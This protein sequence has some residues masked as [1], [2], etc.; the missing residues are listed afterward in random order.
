MPGADAMRFGAAHGAAIFQQSL[1][2]IPRTLPLWLLPAAALALGIDHFAPAR[3]RRM[4]SML[5]IGTAGAAGL[6]LTWTI[7]FAGVSGA[8]TAIRLRTQTN[9]TMVPIQIVCSD[10]GQ[11]V[12]A[13]AHYVPLADSWYVDGVFAW[14]RRRGGGAAVVR[15]LLAR[16]DEQRVALT[17]TALSPSVAAGYRRA[18]FRYLA[19]IYFMRREPVT[20][21]A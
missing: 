2:G 14:P 15:R 9:K 4:S 19:W 10:G 5:L 11:T 7:G 18:G 17:L 16:A 8:R 13:C 21:R 20:E 12:I 3:S 1:E 6:Q